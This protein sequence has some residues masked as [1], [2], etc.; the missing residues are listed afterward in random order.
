MEVES[1][2]AWIASVS[3]LYLL[4]ATV[5]AVGADDALDTTWWPFASLD[6][7]DTAI[8]TAGRTL[9]AAHRPLLQRGL[10]HLTQ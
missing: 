1:D 8:T 9:Y 2:H 10:D 5:T 7:L 4:P 3:A 6:Q